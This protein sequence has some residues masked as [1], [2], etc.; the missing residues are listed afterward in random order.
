MRDEK[1]NEIES[2]PHAEQTVFIKTD[3]KLNNMDILRRKK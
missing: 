1:E 2:A 3:L